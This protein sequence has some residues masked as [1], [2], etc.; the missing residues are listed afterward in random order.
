MI[1]NFFKDYKSLLCYSIITIISILFI[2]IITY[3]SQNNCF[4]GD[5]AWFSLY[6][7]EEGIFDCLFS[8]THGGK[9]LG[10]FIDK[11]L[12]FGLPCLLGIHP[13]NFISSWH[14]L[15]RAVL[16][17]I[18]LL[19]MCNFSVVH[20]K[21]KNLYT[22]FY[23]FLL[24]IVFNYLLANTMIINYYYSFYRYFFSLLFFSIFWL[25]LYKQITGIENNPSKKTL[26]A[27]TFCGYV[28]GTSSEIIFFS[29]CFLI[30]LIITY[31]KIIN[32]I[33]LRTDNDFI[34]SLKIKL[35][36]SFN[37]PVIGFMT[38]LV[39]FIS[40]SGFKEVYADR[41]IT[42]IQ[43]VTYDLFKEFMQLFYNNCILNIKEFWIVFIFLF[44]IAIYFSIRKKELKPVIFNFMYIIALFSV[45]FSLILCGKNLYGTFP[46]HHTNILF[47]YKMM[48]L[49]PFAILLSYTY[50]CM[51]KRKY[52][53]IR[54][55]SVVIIAFIYINGSFLFNLNIHQI[56]DY[57][58]RIFYRKENNYIM[59]KLARFYYLRN[60]TLIL[61]FNIIYQDLF[62][63][64]TFDKTKCIG[65]DEYNHFANIYERIFKEE[66]HVIPS[67]CVRKNAIEEFYSKGGYITKEELNKLDF[68]RLYDKNNI[69]SNEKKEKD[70]I[71]TP[72]EIKDLI[73][74]DKVSC[75]DFLFKDE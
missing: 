57:Q 10:L 36:S 21:S 34:N 17:V 4:W 49:I 42:N 23:C 35:N 5:D 6:A 45:M 68:N 74:K 60:E 43:D 20:E 39:L 12:S 51:M 58:D 11:F 25:F 30:C 2:Q 14:A 29:S 75:N 71:Y 33:S 19:L 7:K 64:R 73:K 13:E 28:I 50:S 3:L 32:I 16:I 27:V 66:V 31:A 56:K 62:D 41:T 70:E 55:Y 18:T 61:P 26:V 15:F 38:G 59:Y 24:I 53:L 8:D 1:K 22:L 47:L 9:Y 48:L 54:F 44:G 52:N 46:L 40:S 69:I 37:I 65:K 63:E 67:L 72:S